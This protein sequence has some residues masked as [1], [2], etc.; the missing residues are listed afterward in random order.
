VNE[1]SLTLVNGSALE[2]LSALLLQRRRGEESPCLFKASTEVSCTNLTQLSYPVLQAMLALKD[3]VAFINTDH[4]SEALSRYGV[5][6][7]LQGTE[8]EKS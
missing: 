4:L 5:S 7:F 1:K 3:E 6:T 8:E 2:V